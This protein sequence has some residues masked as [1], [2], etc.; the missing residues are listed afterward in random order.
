MS[1]FAAHFLLTTELIMRKIRLACRCFTR[2]K[3]LLR[4]EKRLSCMAASVLCEHEGLQGAKR[5]VMSA[6]NEAIAKS[7]KAKRVRQRKCSR[8]RQF[9]HLQKL[10]NVTIATDGRALMSTQCQLFARENPRCLCDRFRRGSC[11]FCRGSSHISGTRRK[12]A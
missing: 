1:A 10:G 12:W 11:R 5:C 3:S 6:A 8:P 9:L 2:R 4:A 7:R